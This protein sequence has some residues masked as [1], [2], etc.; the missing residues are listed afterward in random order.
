[1][2]DTTQEELSR[3]LVFDI[4]SSPR[5]R[6]M[7]Y[8]LRQESEPVHIQ[9][10]SA[11]VASWENEIPV[12][13]LTNQQQKRVYVSLYQ[14]HIPKLED[15]G[16]VTYDQE[17]GTVELTERVDEME[18]YIGGRERREF[19]WQLAY[20]GLAVAGVLLFAAVLFQ[21]GVFAAVSPVAAGVAISAAFAVLAIVNFLSTRW[22]GRN[23]ALEQ[24]E[25]ER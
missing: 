12:D 10:L 14:T 17:T 19:P 15:A 9:K 2:S 22:P 23:G 7:L 24:L 16:I 13:D 18:A 21:V 25:E 6:Y 3:D 1:M 20:L 8:Y 11:E 5:R 4:L